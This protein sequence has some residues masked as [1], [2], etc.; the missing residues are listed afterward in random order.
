MRCNDDADCN[1]S[2]PGGDCDIE[3]DTDGECSVDCAP[4][5]NCNVD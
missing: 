4:F 2:C 3:C 5:D 1:F